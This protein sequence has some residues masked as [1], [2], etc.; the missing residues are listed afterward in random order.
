MTCYAAFDDA[1]RKESEESAR[2]SKH[3]IAPRPANTP[4]RHALHGA[5]V[6]TPSAVSVARNLR[7][8]SI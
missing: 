4:L 8:A 1:S 3:G 5:R 7:S 6:I 2:R